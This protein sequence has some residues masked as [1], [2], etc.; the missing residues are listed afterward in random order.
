MLTQ[1]SIRIV[2]QKQTRTII[3]IFEQKLVTYIKRLKT[4]TVSEWM[5]R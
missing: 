4:K 1:N 2:N 5:E 3:I